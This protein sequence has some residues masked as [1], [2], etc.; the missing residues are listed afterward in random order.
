MYMLFRSLMEHK[1]LRGV[2]SLGSRLK[3]A[4]NVTTEEI[5]D[6]TL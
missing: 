5:G 4:T 3:P 1:I 2:L 6:V